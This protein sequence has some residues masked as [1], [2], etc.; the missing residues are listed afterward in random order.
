MCAFTV[1]VNQSE[2]GYCPDLVDAP[3]WALTELMIESGELRLLM[4]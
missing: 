1:G 2:M 4:V 3:V